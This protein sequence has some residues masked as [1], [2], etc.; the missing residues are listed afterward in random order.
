MLVF[1]LIQNLHCTILRLFSSG[2]NLL[3]IFFPQLVLKKIYI[4]VSETTSYHPQP[5]SFY[6]YCGLNIVR[7]EAITY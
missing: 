4:F 1:E 6:S 5:V 2:S 7:S 3:C